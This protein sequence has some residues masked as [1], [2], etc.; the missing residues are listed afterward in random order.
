[1]FKEMT[2]PGTEVIRAQLY[3]REAEIT[4]RRDLGLPSAS[5]GRL[6]VDAPDLDVPVVRE[7]VRSGVAM[8]EWDARFVLIRDA[9]FSEPV[10]YPCLV[11]RPHELAISRSDE[12]M[13]AFGAAADA[14]LMQEAQDGGLRAAEIARNDLRR[15]SGFV[16]RPDVP[17]IDACA[18]WPR[19]VKA[20]KPDRHGRV[21][22]AVSLPDL[23]IREAVSVNE[24]F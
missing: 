10:G 9:V 21:I 24:P 5:V 15:K 11:C 6:A 14:E 22:D 7:E 12:A 13:P 17:E 16:Q 23:S 8:S 20:I 4:V 2:I 18:A 19:N 1:M 3:E